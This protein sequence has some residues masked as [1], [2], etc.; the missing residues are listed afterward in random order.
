[1]VVTGR[2]DGVLVVLFGGAVLDDAFND[3]LLLPDAVSRRYPLLLPA[4]PPITTTEL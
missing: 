1:M 4:E 3:F 2:G